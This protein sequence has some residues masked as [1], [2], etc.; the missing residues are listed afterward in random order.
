[1]YNGTFDRHSDI[2]IVVHV[3]L[4]DILSLLNDSK[5]KS[6]RRYLVNLYIRK[7]K[8]PVLKV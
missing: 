4:S 2:D 7:A 5:N 3:D 6:V 1:M 8:V